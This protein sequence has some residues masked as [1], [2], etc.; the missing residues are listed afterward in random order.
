MVANSADLTKTLNRLLDNPAAV[1][2]TRKFLKSDS[3]SERS[4]LGDGQVANWRRRG[5][6]PDT[7]VEGAAL[8]HCG[9]HEKVSSD[10]YDLVQRIG[11]KGDTFWQVFVVQD[12]KDHNPRKLDITILRHWQGVR[13][14][15][16]TTHLIHT[17][18]RS[19]EKSAGKKKRKSD[20]GSLKEHDP[21][22]KEDFDD[23]GT[24]VVSWE[25]G[26]LPDDHGYEADFP[27]ALE[28]YNV[29]SAGGYPAIPVDTAYVL[30][31]LPRSVFESQPIESLPSNPRGLPT[32]ISTH[33]MGNPVNVME[34][35]LGIGKVP[36]SKAFRRVELWFQEEQQVVRWLPNSHDSDDSHDFPDVPP[37]IREHGTFKNAVKSVHEGGHRAFATQVEKPLPFLFYF[38]VFGWTVSK[39]QGVRDDSTDSLP[40]NQSIAESSPDATAS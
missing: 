37:L 10:Q 1:A 29:E 32:A 14:L 8:Y 28:K 35:F 31:F 36:T 6:L 17:A 9:Y 24:A 20:V 15:R 12:S 39:A 5:R 7:F 38:M 18:H 16:G 30:I 22:F 11:I 40:D 25:I 4:G 34:S 21:S 33:V 2:D 26:R 13:S 19:I 23:D 27:N 3:G